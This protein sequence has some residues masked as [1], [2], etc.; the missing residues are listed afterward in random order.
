VGR[1]PSKIAFMTVVYPAMRPYLDDFLRSLQQ[2]SIQSFDLVVCNDE[3]R[4]FDFSVHGFNVRVVNCSGTPAAIREQGIRWLIENDYEQAIFGD[5][6]DFFDR[7]RV[8]SALSL[9]DRYDIVANDISLVDQA[10]NL[11]LG[12]YFT[13]RIKHLDEIPPDF[14]S[15]CNI[16][17]LSNTAVRL[18]CWEN[19]ECPE[20]LI[21]ADWYLFSTA[22]RNGS[23]AV[24]NAESTTFYR[25][26]GENTVGF[27]ELTL[28]KV[29][30][31]VRTKM[32]HYEASC[33]NARVDCRA[34]EGFRALYED[35]VCNSQHLKNYFEFAT[36]RKPEFPFWWEEIILPEEYL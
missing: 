10:G 3:L 30:A 20:E 2:Q 29:L 18:A 26:H 4:D 31:G 17:G 36:S 12:N 33:R 34:G 5:S 1:E 24:F 21:A 16:F 22:L 13:N 7:R 23:R 28:E 19:V 35:I 32:L 27:K 25:Q 15:D 11:L 8:E 6:D 9:L 14:V